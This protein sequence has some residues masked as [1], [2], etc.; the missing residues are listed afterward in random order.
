MPATPWAAEGVA[1][2]GP[3]FV[4]GRA[5]DVWADLRL[6][7]LRS[8]RFC[9]HGGYRRFAQMHDAGSRKYAA[10]TGTDFSANE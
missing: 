7:R 9:E 6:R 8:A 4:Q 5:A 3:V 10:Q 1:S 2:G